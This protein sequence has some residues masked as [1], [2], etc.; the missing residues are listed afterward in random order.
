M[1]QAFGHRSKFGFDDFNVDVRPS[2]FKKDSNGN[3]DAETLKMANIGNATVAGDSISYSQVFPTLANTTV[4]TGTINGV[5][6]ASTSIATSSSITLLNTTDSQYLRVG[7]GSGAG[8]GNIMM[9]CLTGAAGGFSELSF[10][11][12]YIAGEQRFNTAKKRYRF[13]CDQRGSTDVLS[14]ESYD[15]A[16]RTHQHLTPS[17]GNELVY[18]FG[19][20][21][22]STGSA[23]NNSSV[24]SHYEE[25]NVATVTLSGA[26]S[27]T[28]TAKLTR[29]GRVV[30]LSMP[31]KSMSCIVGGVGILSDV[32]ISSQLRPTVGHRQI[33]IIAYDDGSR[34]IPA[35][36]LV[37]TTG[38]ISIL[39]F[40]DNTTRQFPF[41]P[42]GFTNGT[43]I[44]Y[45]TIDV[46]WTI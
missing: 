33:P 11:G 30:H 20:R 34:L 38:A 22:S 42:V 8:T 3:Y 13:I 24:L 35:G 5:G 23:D 9:H 40:L 2:R 46:S 25:L 18:P 43:T 1:N 21:L 15:G 12:Y 27:D 29:I 26:V 32:F 17:G 28:T 14:L 39:S 45:D 41:S 4:Q 36:I 6:G 44:A 10:N 31:T 7:T 37:Q 19:I 16:L